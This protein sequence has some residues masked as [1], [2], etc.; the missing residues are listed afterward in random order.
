[1][2]ESGTCQHHRVVIGSLRRVPPRLPLLVPD[3]ISDGKS[4]NPLREIPPDAHSKVHL[5]TYSIKS[6]RAIR[7]QS[8]K[9]LQKITGQFEGKTQ[10]VSQ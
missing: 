6:M 5:G 4:D 3:V 1:M 8:W 9:C 2:K 10:I 7:R